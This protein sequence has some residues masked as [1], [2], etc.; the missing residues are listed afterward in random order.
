MATRDIAAEQRAVGA[1]RAANQ[2]RMPDIYNNPAERAQVYKI[3]YPP[4]SGGLPDELKGTVDESLYSGGL[5]PAGAINQPVKINAPAG[6]APSTVSN[7]ESAQTAISPGGQ[8]SA[9]NVNEFGRVLQDSIRRSAGAQNVQLGESTLFNKAGVGGYNV[10]AQSLQSHSNEM[11]KSSADLQRLVGDLTGSY[12]AK[13]QDAMN[14]YK[15]AQDQ[16]NQEAD[17]LQQ[18]ALQANEQNN[19]IKRLKQ[20]QIIDQENTAFESKFKG[21]QAGMDI[22]SLLS[23]D[24][25]SKFIT[26]P[27]NNNVYDFSNYAVDPE[28]GTAINNNLQSIGKFNNKEDIANYISQ[29]APSSNITADAISKASEKYGVSW[30]LLTSIIQ[31]ES[32]LGISAN[33]INNNN[34]GGITWNAEYEKNHPGTSKGGVRGIGG[35]EGG[36]YVKFGSIQ[37]GIDAVAEQI[38]RRNRGQAEGK[39]ISSSG[40]QTELPFDDRT[41]ALAYNSVKSIVVGKSPTG[42]ESFDRAF[43]N[44]LSTGKKQAFDYLQSQ[45]ATNVLG[46]TEAKGFYQIKEG[47]ANYDEAIKFLESKPNL[48]TGFY[49]ETAEGL[50]PKAFAKKDPEYTTLL[51]YVNLAEAPI[52][53]TLYGQALTPNELKLA[54]R[55]MLNTDDD[56]ST[57]LLKLRQARNAY[58]DGLNDK[59]FQIMGIPYAKPERQG[60]AGSVSPD[61][62]TLG[63]DVYLLQ[64]NGKYIKQ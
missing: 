48:T 54:Q 31:H 59:M 53:Q 3:A 17:R 41:L 23:G 32:N 26:D 33:A 57:I 64:S 47:L 10:L 42:L 37:S 45:Y 21:S 18:L 1:F 35:I 62:M 29:V 40:M 51:N 22:F 44:A 28:W 6:M 14:Q 12:A 52:R 63:S 19:Y 15:M 36:N 39:V 61:K 24:T 60:A 49:K 58:E 30:E 34:F 43:S 13:A 56:R 2:G 7:L 25:S 27:S 16:Y 38:A 20:Q 5:T 9:G 50:K 55:S 46:P 8:F 4:D 11:I